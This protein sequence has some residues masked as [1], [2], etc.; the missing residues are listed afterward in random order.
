MTRQQTEFGLGNVDICIGY[1]FALSSG[2]NYTLLLS[3]VK[4]KHSAHFHLTPRVYFV[5]TGQGK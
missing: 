4:T 3:S 2:S 5:H 1:M